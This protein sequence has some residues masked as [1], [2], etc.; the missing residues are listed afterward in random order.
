MNVV[1]PDVW[2]P[3]LGAALGVAGI[4]WKLYESGK[5]GVGEMLQEEVTTLKVELKECQAERRK[6]IT[7]NETLSGQLARWKAEHGTPEQR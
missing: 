3:M 5:H 7:D 1:S 2:P 6:L 4:I